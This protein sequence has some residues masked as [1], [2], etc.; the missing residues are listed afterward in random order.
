MAKAC[1]ELTDFN[2][3]AVVSAVIKEKSDDA[4]GCNI[5]NNFGYRY[6]EED[7][8]LLFIIQQMGKSFT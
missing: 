1:F 3:H 7:N 5:E 6:V 2:I 8:H 4:N